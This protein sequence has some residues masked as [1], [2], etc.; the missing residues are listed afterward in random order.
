MGKQ[1]KAHCWKDEAFCACHAMRH[2]AINCEKFNF[3]AYLLPS[4][5]TGPEKASGKT[6]KAA[7]VSVGITC[8]PALSKARAFPTT[9]PQWSVERCGYLLIN[10]DYFFLQPGT[11]SV[12]TCQSHLNVLLWFMFL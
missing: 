7:L 3:I 1:N 10:F 2:E 9:Q 11:T 6:A 12:H 4:D 8:T 5:T